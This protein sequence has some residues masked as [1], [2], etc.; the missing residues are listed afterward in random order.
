M[1]IPLWFCDM[2]LSPDW[3]RGQFGLPGD[4]NSS[5]NLSRDPVVGD[6]Y[7]AASINRKPAHT[8]A[9]PAALLSAK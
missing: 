3:P 7:R 8:A 2:K 4:T 1:S 5:T 6:P 9:S